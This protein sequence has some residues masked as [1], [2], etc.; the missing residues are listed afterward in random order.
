MRSRQSRRGILIAVLIQFGLVGLIAPLVFLGCGGASEGPAKLIPNFSGTTLKIG[1]IGDPAILAGAKLQRGEWMA[2]RS[3]AL[4]FGDKSIEVKDVSGVDVFLFP[5]ERMGDLVDAGTLAAIPRSA[6][7]VIRPIDGDDSVDPVK[8][9]DDQGKPKESAGPIESF[10]YTDIAPVF[11][12]QVAKYGDE[13]MALPYGGSALVLIYRQDAFRRE[14]NQKAAKE[15]GVVLDAP[16]TWKDFEALARFFQKRDWDGDGLPD[17]GVSLALGE[18]TDSVANSVYLARAASAGKHRDFFSFLFDAETMAPRLG[19]PPFVEALASLV[20]LRDC[21]PPGIEKFDAQAARAAFRAGH[22]AMLID[23]AER[24]STWSHGKPIGVAPLPGSGR[25]YHP[26]NNTWE[27]VSP[28]NA[29]TYLPL[30]GGWLIGVRRGLE[31]AKLEAAI[32]FARFLADPD[33]SNRV[34][35]ERSFA[36]LPF[37]ISQMGQG[38]P[39]PT[40]AADVDVRLWSDSVSR[41]LMAAQVVAGLRIPEADG[42]LADL[43][44][45]RLAALNGESVEKALGGVVEGWTKRT[46]KLGPKRQAWHYRRSLNSLA[47]VSEPPPRGR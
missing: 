13:L 15:A 41:T 14:A 17:F 39:D 27:D 44:K 35:A 46:A 6:L 11:R 45:G 30:G 12:D 29:P 47:T 10:Q 8:E 38:M 42:Y 16:K 19:S 32:D 33:N 34:R 43:T 40:S 31:G 2:S 18:D 4:E 3:G 23:R 37:R 25:V 1:A 20:S 22:S 26:Q 28:P 7:M 9:E 24:A 5:G 21:G 36:M